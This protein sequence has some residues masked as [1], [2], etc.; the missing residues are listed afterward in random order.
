MKYALAETRAA[1]LRDLA[2]ASDAVAVPPG[3]THTAWALEKRGL[4]K[5]I[6]RG[7]GHVVVV[8]VDGHCYLKYGENQ[9]KP[10]H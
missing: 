2:A 8:G 3:S 1:T 6:W 7:S 9:E 4:I 5:R 10:G